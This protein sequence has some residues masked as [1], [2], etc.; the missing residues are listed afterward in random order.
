MRGID[1]NERLTLMN[2]LAI[3][4]FPKKMLSR[5]QFKMSK[6]LWISPEILASMKQKISY[7]INILKL[8]VRNN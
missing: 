2:N 6:N 4:H 1:T 5:K 7:T 8:N 3:R